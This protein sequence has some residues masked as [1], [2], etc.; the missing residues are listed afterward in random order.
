MKNS[1]LLLATSL[2]G[3][4]LTSQPAAAQEVVHDGV[5]IAELENAL[6]DVL[7][8]TSDTLSDGSKILFAKGKNHL[9]GVVLVHCGN[10][11]RCEGIRYFAV[12]DRKLSSTFINQFNYK[13][14]YVKIATN[15]KGEHGIVLELLAAG[16]VTDANLANN[17]GMLMARMT[18][19]NTVL[20]SQVSLDAPMA[21]LSVDMSA[22][23]TQEGF[24]N[25]KASRPPAIAL[26]PKAIR[27]I[28]EL[29]MARLN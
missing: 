6:S 12:V 25:L 3:A 13:F 9:I 18:Q 17:A 22:A 26:D 5:T 10:S 8:V 28:V 24:V 29:A 15:A 27:A 19:L 16:G 20:D 11:T 4:S 2:I 14:D 1:R 21:S 7:I 23:L